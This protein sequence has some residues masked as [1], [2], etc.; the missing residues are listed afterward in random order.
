VSAGQNVLALT[1]GGGHVYSPM[2]ITIDKDISIIL[3][4]EL[5][6]RP[7]MY[8]WLQEAPLHCIPCWFS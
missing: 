2:A 7:S 8:V 6:S 4:V 3:K 1:L 5:G